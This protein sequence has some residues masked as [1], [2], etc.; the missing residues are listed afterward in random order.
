MSV[1]KGA[2]ERE[3]QAAWQLLASAVDS[4]SEE[5]MVHP[6]VVDGW[7]IK[8][9]LGHVAFWADKAAADLKL[10]AAGR[11]QDVE[12]PGSEEAVDEWNERER[13]ARQ[14]RPLPEVR[15]EWLASYQAA[16]EAL[17]AFPAERLEENVKGSTVL[18]RF[19]GDTYEH[20]REHAAHLMSWRRE[21]ETTE[22]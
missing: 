21:L 7:S 8:D 3:M 10:I 19:A 5:E 15:E 20:Y 2:M 1:D 4:F 22:T 6:G 14:G 18:E 9:L 12:V 16:M 17:A 11:P 13:E